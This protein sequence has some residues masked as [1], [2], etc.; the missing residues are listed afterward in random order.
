M[1]W[2]HAVWESH[3]IVSLAISLIVVHWTPLG[4]DL[5]EPTDRKQVPNYTDSRS[6]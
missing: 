6:Y 5:I 2:P 1:K 3:P 4:Q